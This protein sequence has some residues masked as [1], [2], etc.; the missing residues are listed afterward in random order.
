MSTIFFFDCFQ[1]SD[2]E[3]TNKAS[4]ECTS[5]YEKNSSS[6][7]GFEPTN[8]GP[9]EEHVDITLNNNTF[10]FLQRLLVT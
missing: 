9:G 8:L 3:Q 4:L 10:L 5:R 7:V 6:S 2:S 1:G